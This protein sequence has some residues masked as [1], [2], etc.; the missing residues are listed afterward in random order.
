[1]AIN[2]LAISSPDLPALARIP[3]AFAKD[4][5]NRTP[6]LT[7]TGIPEGTVELTVV[8][9]DPDAPMPRGFTHWVLHGLA[10]AETVE[11]AEAVGRPAPN[12]TG[13]TGYVGPYPPAGHGQHHY[14][15][16]AYAL[17][18]TVEGAP[19][20]EEFLERYAGDILEQARFVATYSVD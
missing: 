12:S 17:G 16:W 4:G 7:I 18:T 6:R 2:A 1:M 11:V 15:F 20:R 3:D 5:G 8:C 13:E 9:H 19:T 14:Y 10:P